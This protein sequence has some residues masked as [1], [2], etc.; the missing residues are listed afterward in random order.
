MKQNILSWNTFNSVSTF[1]CSKF[2]VSYQQK[3][4]VYR[5]KMPSYRENLLALIL[6]NKISYPKNK[7]DK[8][9]KGPKSS[10]WNFG[11]KTGT[12]KVH[13]LI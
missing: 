11:W 9:S 8:K 5:Q 7:R 12:A 13:M 3:K 10:D 6:I 2:N 1:H 4:C